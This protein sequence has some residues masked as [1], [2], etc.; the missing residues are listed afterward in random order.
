MKQDIFG[1]SHEGK[2]TLAY[3]DFPAPRKTRGFKQVSLTNPK[4]DLKTTLSM[5]EIEHA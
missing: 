3:F 2:K 5:D 1:A 4:I